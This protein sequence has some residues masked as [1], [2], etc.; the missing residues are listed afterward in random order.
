MVTFLSA[1]IARP[2][3]DAQCNSETSYDVGPVIDGV[4]REWG[5]MCA[6][7]WKLELIGTVY[8]VGGFVGVSVGGWMSDCYGRRT[9][10]LALLS[11]CLPS[12]PTHPNPP[13]SGPY[14]PYPENPP[15][16]SPS[17]SPS[18][19]DVLPCLPRLPC[20]R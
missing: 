9:A 6:G 1:Y 10:T 20:L 2:I 19:P 8:F 16:P 4:A 14:Q 13:P 15:I 12:L 11:E 3:K 5:L 18:R 17:P 7:E